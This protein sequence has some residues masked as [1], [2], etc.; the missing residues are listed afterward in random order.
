MTWVL[1]TLLGCAPEEGGLND[2]AVAEEAVGLGFEAANKSGGE[3]MPP[4]RRA[5]YRDWDGDGY[6]AGTARWTCRRPGPNWVVTDGDCDDT[7]AAVYPEADE[8]L[9]GV[10]D[11]CDGTADDGCLFNVYLFHDEYSAW[12]SDAFVDS[13]F[14]VWAWYEGASDVSVEVMWDVSDRPDPADSADDLT[15]MMMATDVA[16]HP[17]LDSAISWDQVGPETWASWPQE[18]CEGF[19][20]WTDSA[21]AEVTLYHEVD[22]WGYGTGNCRGYFNSSPSGGDTAT[23]MEYVP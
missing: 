8:E 3:G 11:D 16:D 15:V 1:L 12:S 5:W 9:N 2:E 10:D 7:D 13:P 20:S 21:Y 23:W 22:A 14:W 6:G 18:G 17:W 4:C 19:E